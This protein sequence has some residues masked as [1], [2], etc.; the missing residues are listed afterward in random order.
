MHDIEVLSPLASAASRLFSDA[1]HYD[2]L[3]LAVFQSA[4]DDACRALGLDSTSCGDADGLAQ[5]RSRVAAAVLDKAR[6]GERDCAV[7]A[8]FAVARGLRHW[9]VG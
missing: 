2:S 9:P 7:L 1:P 5:V 4:F 6:S 8:S 3:D